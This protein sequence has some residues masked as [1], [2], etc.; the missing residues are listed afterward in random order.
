MDLDEFRKKNGLN[1]SLFEGERVL[2]SLVGT[3]FGKKRGG[4]ML[5]LPSGPKNIPGNISFFGFLENRIRLTCG[6]M[7]YRPSPQ[8]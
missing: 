7:V 4:I 6:P 2:G 3:K 5:Q 1:R 8:G